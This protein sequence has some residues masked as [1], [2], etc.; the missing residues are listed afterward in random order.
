MQNQFSGRGFMGVSLAAL[1]LSSVVNSTEIQ[2]MDAEK[3][4]TEVTSVSDQCSA[5]TGEAKVKMHI[6]NIMSAEGNI[7]VQAY[8][9]APEE[10]LEKGKKLFRYEVKAQEE[11]NFLCV[12]M[13]APGRY[14]L[15]VLH[16][17]NANGKADFF[18]EGFGFS[19]NP[20][21]GLAKPD[22]DEVVMSTPEGVTEISV[23]LTYILG[24]DEENA[25]K[26]RRS[27][28]R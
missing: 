28:R 3:S 17:R 26:R 27:R 25:K 2:A 15:V 4:D 11:G 13:P 5:D 7:R 14:A 10:F 21:L 18:S 22:H 1:L 16:D 6:T 19:N 12:S 23:K 24:G 8:S 9:D 20:K